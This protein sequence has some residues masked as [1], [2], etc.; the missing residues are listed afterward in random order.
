VIID[1]DKFLAAERPFWDEL[2]QFLDRLTTNPNRWIELAQARRF[3]YLYER[4]SA[5][6]GKLTTFASEPDTR[7]YLEALVARAYGEIHE[8]RERQHHFSPLDWFLKTFPQTFRRHA[9]AFQFTVLIT[10]AGCLFG[11]G[12]TLFDPD[13]RHA[14]MPFGHDRLRP[15]ERVQRE[16]E[17]TVDRLAGAKSSFST[18]LMTHNTRV[19]VLTLA[20]GMTWAVGTIVALFYNGVVLGAICTDYLSDGQGAF[21]AGW[22][23]PHGSIEIPAI[24]ISGQAGLVLGH[25]LIGWG[26]RTPLSERLRAIAPDLA[27]LIGGVAL[28]LVWAGLIEAFFSQYHEPVLP[29]A[30]KTA[31]GLVELALLTLFLLRA[32]RGIEEGQAAAKVK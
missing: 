22:L 29:Y 4:T 15:S 30:V 2:E 21:L 26:M 27:T 1:L 32:G 19:S 13:S 18:F 31:F 9:R 6:L 5:D 16:E 14:T 7:H 20:L 10:I 24:L 17:S 28:L 23:L 11:T 8:T 25:A 3:H 12:A